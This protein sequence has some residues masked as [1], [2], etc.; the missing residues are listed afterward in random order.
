MATI[1]VDE[2]VYR[3]IQSL[4]KPL[5]DTPNSVLRRVAGLDNS[6]KPAQTE[7]VMHDTTVSSSPSDATEHHSGAYLA[8]LW[9][10]N[11]D[12]TFYHKDGT[13]YDLLERF[14]GALFDA[15]GYVLFADRNHYRSC[16]Y[17]RFTQELNVPGGI[18]S[19]SGYKKMR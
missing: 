13:S 6:D 5:E 19:I 8:Q 14:P 11:A 16:S 3:W 10:V 18:A 9:G 17:L 1:E 4:A 15:N 2:E 12:Q 7:E